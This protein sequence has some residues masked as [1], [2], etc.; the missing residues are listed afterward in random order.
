M[1]RI[2]PLTGIALLVAACSSENA[3][4]PPPAPVD[5]HAFEVPHAQH[6]GPTG[7]TRRERAV[8]ESFIAAFSAPSWGEL[9][10]LVAGDAHYVW[11]G[12]PDARGHDAVLK[13]FDATFGAFDKRALVPSRVLRSDAATS[14]E[15]TFSGVQARDWMG[16]AATSKPVSFRGVALLFTKDDGGIADLHVVFDLAVVKAQL[17]AGPKELA[18]L[19]PAAP[20]AGP[21]QGVEAAHTPDE[22][23]SVQV[24][25]AWLDAL[26][27]NDEPG[28]L[29]ALTDDAALETLERAQPAHGR[30][31]MKAHFRAMHRAISQLD[32][33][34]DNAWGVGKYAVVEYYVAGEQVAPLG[35]LPPQRN[36]VVRLQ[37]V[38]VMEMRDG[39]IAHVWRYE[40]PAQILTQGM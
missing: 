37:V 33:T 17:G 11:P 10:Q 27:K 3:S 19:P 40:N 13:A 12:M 30:E 29:A 14:V 35:W 7:P 32:T 5:W 8:A 24:A 39:K 25:R 38:D 36:K 26:E 31:E 6:T 23:R 16:V 1:H 22:T 4:S 2:L 9:P 28:W 18:A 34:L 20:P 21:V 15:W